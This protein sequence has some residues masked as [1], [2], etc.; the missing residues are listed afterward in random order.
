MFQAYQEQ[1]MLVWQLRKPLQPGAELQI[2]AAAPPQYSGGTLLNKPWFDY[3]V[4]FKRQSTRGAGVPTAGRDLQDIASNANL[5]LNVGNLAVCALE[6]IHTALDEGMFHPSMLDSVDADA[7]LDRVI[8]EG[9]TEV[10]CSVS[11]TLQHRSC[12]ATCYLTV[13]AL[14][15]MGA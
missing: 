5:M 1:L 12:L 6:H 10:S 13:A 9:D 4:C 15:T 7:L 11:R 2:P 14:E 3:V 8:A